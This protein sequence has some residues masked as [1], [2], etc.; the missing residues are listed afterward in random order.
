MVV[1]TALGAVVGTVVGGGFLLTLNSVV[2]YCNGGPGRAPCGSIGLVVPTGFVVWAL[3]AGLFVV[4]GFHFLHQRHGLWVVGAGAVLWVALV[5]AVYH[6]S[7]EYL[8]LYQADRGPVIAVAI[9]IAPCVSYAVAALSIGRDAPVARPA[10][11]QS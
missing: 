3:L 6:V 7:R 2:R 10:E 1:R 11:S 8:D 4:A 5:A 9:V